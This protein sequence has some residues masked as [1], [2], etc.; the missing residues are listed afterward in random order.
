VLDSLFPFSEIEMLEMGVSEE[1]RSLFKVPEA[2]LVGELD[3]EF[4]K[5]SGVV[6]TTTISLVA[7]SKSR[8]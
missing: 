5:V 1:L 3:L 8:F 6:S 2:E 7:L 4:R